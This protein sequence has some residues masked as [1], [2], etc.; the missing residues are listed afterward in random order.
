MSVMVHLSDAVIATVES[1]AGGLAIGWAW[2]K[3]IEQKPPAGADTAPEPLAVALET[4]EEEE[5][6]TVAGKPRK[7][8]WKQRRKELEAKARTKRQ[9]IEEWRD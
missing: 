2:F 4:A 6:F 9:A 7:P 5:T 1:F 3:P 8:S